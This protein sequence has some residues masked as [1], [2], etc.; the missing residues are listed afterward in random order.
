MRPI[1]LGEL[2]VV[3]GIDGIMLLGDSRKF[4]GLTQEE[5]SISPGPSRVLAKHYAHV[6]SVIADHF[7]NTVEPWAEQAD[8]M[9]STITLEKAEAAFLRLLR[10]YGFRSE[11]YHQAIT[12]GPT[13]LP[14]DPAEWDY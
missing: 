4:H 13:E 2:T 12:E 3:F 9:Q 5:S 8:S 6:F 11:E 1:K 7:K 10:N 14:S